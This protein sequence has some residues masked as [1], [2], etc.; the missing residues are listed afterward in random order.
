MSEDLSFFDNVRLPSEDPV[1]A[2]ISAQDNNSLLSQHGAF[3]PVSGS[4]SPLYNADVFQPSIETDNMSEG[5]HDG[6]FVT[7]EPDDTTTAMICSTPDFD[8]R[9]PFHM[10]EN[11]DDD[12]VI[13]EEADCFGKS[14]QLWSISKSKPTASRRGS[15][16]DIVTKAEPRTEPPRANNLMKI[17]KRLMAQ[18]NASKMRKSGAST[19]FGPRTARQIS[20][21]ESPKRKAKPRRGSIYQQKSLNDIVDVKVE[22]ETLMRRRDEN[23]SWMEE[24]DDKN[25]EN[26]EFENL[27]RLRQAF[28]KRQNEGSLT[29]VETIEMMKI[30]QQ[31]ELR[32]RFQETAN[33]LNQKEVVVVSSDDE[34]E[35]D[36]AERLLR[37]SWYNQVHEDDQ[38]ARTT[39]RDLFQDTREPSQTSKPKGSK[40]P[41]K[42]KGRTFAKTAREVEEKRREKEREKER[43]KRARAAL[44]KRAPPKKKGAKK[45]GKGATKRDH[46]SHMKNG[47]GSGAEALH[48][49]LQD[50]V[51]ND[52][53]ADRLAQGKLPEAPQINETRKDKA[54]QAL[55]VSAP[56]DYDTHRARYD[57]SDLN[58]ASKRFGFGRVKWLVDGSWKLKGMKSSL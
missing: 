43:K 6:M 13:V 19:I 20:L 44:S 33:R 4:F 24:E 35:D 1:E 45:P 7:P 17:Q 14:R 49:M 5:N 32:N 56:N 37:Q 41:T 28:Q 18:H 10:R 38:M 54:L 50:L 31:I 30:N 58:R 22:F 36:H 15:S 9:S 51:H 53:I 23:T 12:C 34:G 16:G 48:A 21:S 27:K 26:E 29:E 52:F 40:K 46:K 11:V 25:E 3:P 47:C 42:G 8:Y 39:E 55:L 2:G 57:K